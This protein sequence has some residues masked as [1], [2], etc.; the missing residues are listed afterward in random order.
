[1]A[2]ANLPLT[3]ADQLNDN[4]PIAAFTN[5]DGGEIG[6][7]VWTNP[8]RRGGTAVRRRRVDPGTPATSGAIKRLYDLSTCRATMHRLHLETIPSRRNSGTV[9][10]RDAPRRTL[11][12]GSA[13][14]AGR[15]EEER[16]FH[17]DHS[18]PRCPVCGDQVTAVQVVNRNRKSF[19][20]FGATRHWPRAGSQGGGGLSGHPVDA[21]SS[22][23]CAVQ[24]RLQFPLSNCPRTG[25]CYDL[26]LVRV[27]LRDE[28]PQLTA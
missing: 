2:G 7:A 16:R 27:V 3:V 22:G 5:Q 19:C 9:H 6:C 18:L 24:A 10:Q 26:S 8:F 13:R 23:E 28:K 15:R 14:T 25:R 17:E 20:Y 11:R 1:M 4:D 12:S 21:R